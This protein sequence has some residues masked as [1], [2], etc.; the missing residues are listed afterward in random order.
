MERFLQICLIVLFA[1]IGTATKAQIAFEDVEVENWVGTGSNSTILVIDF[2]EGTGP[3]SFAWGINFDTETITGEEMLNTVSSN[4]AN[5]TYTGSGYVSSIEY[6]D[7]IITHT[8]PEVGWFSTWSATNGED[9]A[10]NNGIADVFSDGTW[11]GV[12]YLPNHNWPGDAPFVPISAPQT[13]EISFANYGI[14]VYEH[15]LLLTLTINK[16]N[17]FADAVTIEYQVENGDAENGVDFACESSNVISWL[18]GNSDAKTIEIQI[19]SDDLFDEANE[20]FTVSLASN[21]GS[22]SFVSGATNTVTIINT[23]APPA[24]NAGTTAIPHD[25]QLFV[26]WGESPTIERGFIDIADESQGLATY[27]T[28]ANGG[29]E[30]NGTVVSLGDGGSATYEF[31]TSIFNGEGFDFAIFENAFDYN[32]LELAFVE[33]SSDGI[34]YVRFPSTSHTQNTTQIDGF[35][36]LVPELIHNLAGKY[37]ANYGTP[38]DLEDLADNSN[39]DLSNIT[40]IRII[41]VV[42]SINPL[43]ASYDAQGNI[44]NDPYPTLFESSGFDLDA[45]GVM[46]K[47]LL[48]I[49][50][51]SNIADVYIYPNPT[52]DFI[53]ISELKSTTKYQLIDINGRIIVAGVANNATEK[54]NISSLTNGV[55]FL[56]ITTDEAT[57]TEKILKI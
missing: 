42:G 51:F 7:G 50:D 11:L 41:D 54:I 18:A 39:I 43:H 55:Y 13:A 20:T 5:F 30:P 19:L 22:A 36:E 16:I 33:V 48:S 38:F 10:T 12:N 2:N 56:Q 32:Y 26:A 8:T 31:A 4:D 14:E 21:D 24:N 9:W 6:F 37:E 23:F 49:S 27:G 25:S 52:A 34:N 57:K 40:N 35:G 3:Q 15:S 44:I 46:Y 17:N 28:E 45:I 29:G 1:L 53:N 47:N